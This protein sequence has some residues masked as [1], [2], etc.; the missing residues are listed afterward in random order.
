MI[1][2]DEEATVLKDHALLIEGESIK[3]ILPAAQACC[4]YADKVLHLPNHV[5][6]PGL[7]NLHGHSAMTLLRGYADDLALMD[8]LNHHIWPAEGKHVNAEFVH[9]GTLLAM[10]EMLRGGTTCINDM[11]FFHAAVAQAALSINMR[12]FV[13]ASICGGR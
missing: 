11:Y 8:W 9:D 10:A 1:P 7:I 13:G 2:I 3:A 5:L 6:M 12:T 4:L